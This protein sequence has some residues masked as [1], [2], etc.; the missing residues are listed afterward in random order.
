MSKKE[1]FKSVKTKNQLK[2]NGKNV[3]E[4]KKGS[5]YNVGNVSTAK[6]C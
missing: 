1:S 4:Y 6:F 3:F 2:V 5:I